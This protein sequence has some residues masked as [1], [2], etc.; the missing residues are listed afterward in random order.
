MKFD[1]PKGQRLHRYFRQV[2]VDGMWWLPEYQKWVEPHE[3][4]G[5]HAQS[6]CNCRTI[7]AFKRHLRIHPYI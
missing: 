1:K 5:N 7:R 6:W 3:V 4:K 2:N